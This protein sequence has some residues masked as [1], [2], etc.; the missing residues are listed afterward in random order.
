MSQ[1]PQHD[2]AKRAIADA[3]RRSGSLAFGVEQPLDGD[4]EDCRVDA[5]GVWRPVEATDI[6]PGASEAVV[7]AEVQFSP[8]TGEETVVRDA[9][10]SAAARRRWPGLPQVR[11]WIFW[12][13]VPPGLEPGPEF[14]PIALRDLDPGLMPISA[15]RSHPEGYQ[16]RYFKDRVLPQVARLTEAIA[17]GEVSYVPRQEVDVAVSPLIAAVRCA[18][19]DC[20]ERHKPMMRL[21]GTA[22]RSDLEAPD[23]PPVYQPVDM[24]GS[25]ER[26]LA[27]DRMLGWLHARALG[28]AAGRALADTGFPVRRAVVREEAGGGCSQRCPSCGWPVARAMEE[29]GLALE[30]A[31]DPLAFER[32]LQGLPIADERIALPVT[33]Q[34]GW[35]FMEAGP[36]RAR[37]EIDPEHLED[38][39]AEVVDDLA[40]S[41]WVNEG[42]DPN[43]PRIMLEGRERQ[44]LKT[45]HNELQAR[46][47]QERLETLDIARGPPAVPEILGYTMTVFKPSQPAPSRSGYRRPPS[48]PVPERRPSSAPSEFRVRPA[49][50][51]VGGLKPRP[52]VRQKEIDR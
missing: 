39:A 10:L 33:I 12:D 44:R 41:V 16:D 30:V 21:C 52:M 23:L 20:S 26:A 6:R 14:F 25:P 15:L 4:R 50:G 24:M 22:L 34:G 8:Q 28:W 27:A 18:N 40:C 46:V 5:F 35:R 45:I 36:E 38:I 51:R 9:R 17:K 11:V 48:R 49:L 47:A 31:R 32:R 13:A 42:R 37:P 2:A 7:L 3:M 29:D 19:P 43:D 1:S